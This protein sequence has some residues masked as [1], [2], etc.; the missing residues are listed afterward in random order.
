M[1]PGPESPENGVMNTGTRFDV[2]VVDRKGQSASLSMPRDDYLETL[3]EF[4]D[5][6]NAQVGLYMDALAGFAGNRVRIEFQVARVLRKSQQRKDPDGVP[7]TVWSSFEDPDSPDVIHNRIT[8]AADYIACNAV[9]G[10]NEQQQVRAIIVLLFAIWDEEIRPRL[11]HCKQLAPNDIRVDALGDLRILRHA[12][13]HN[14]GMLSASAYGKLK[15]MK[16][17]FTASAP[18][19]L[20]HDRMHRLFVTLKQGIAALILDHTGP[21]PGAPR[22]SEIQDVAIQRKA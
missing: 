15:I 7:V 3:R 16:D 17:I 2:F 21:R 10:F 1:N 5:V 4:I 6:V 18:I 8:R 9:H 12:I 19:I 22:I 20:S 13:I 11:A 14:K